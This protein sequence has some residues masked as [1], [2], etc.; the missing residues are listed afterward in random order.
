MRWYAVL[1]KNGFV[2]V[3]RAWK[4]GTAETLQATRNPLV[5]EAFGPFEAPSYPE[6]K[7]HARVILSAVG[8]VVPP[9]MVQK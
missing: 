2:V 9:H 6:A 7:L 8:F 3:S 5:R 1:R 4:A